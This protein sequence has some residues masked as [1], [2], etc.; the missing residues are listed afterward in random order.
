MAPQMTRNKRRG[1]GMTEYIIIVALIAIGCIGVVSAFGNQ[2]RHL[3]GIASDGLA[4]RTDLTT[5]GPGEMETRK[6]LSNFAGAEE[7]GGEGF[8]GN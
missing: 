1:Q 7:G 8:R 6:N 4:G 3:F 2:I 5:Q